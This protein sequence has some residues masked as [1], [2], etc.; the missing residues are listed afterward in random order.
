MFVKTDNKQYNSKI[1]IAKLRELSQGLDLDI[2]YIENLQDKYTLQGT[3]MRLGNDATDYNKQKIAGRMNVF[4]FHRV[5]T[6][7]LEEYL[8]RTK[9]I[10]NDNVYNYIEKNIEF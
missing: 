10:L 5:A 1:S 6:P 3:M 9:Y 7:N 4:N 2:E 8:E